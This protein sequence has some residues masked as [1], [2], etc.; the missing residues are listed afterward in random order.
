MGKRTSPCTAGSSTRVIPATAGR[1]PSA[2]LLPVPPEI[3]EE[4]SRDQAAHQPNYSDDCAKLTRD[5][6]TLTNYDKRDTVGCRSTPELVEVLAV[7]AEVGRRFY[8][9]T[10]HETWQGVMCRHP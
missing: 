3:A 2:Q 1:C 4:T 8:H 5:D 6:W 9:E 7:G 10:P